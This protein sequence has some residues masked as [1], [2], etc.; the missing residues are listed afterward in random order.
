VGVRETLNKKKGVAMTAA[1]VVLCASVAL[2]AWESIG[3]GQKKITKAYYTVDDGKTWF[4]DDA[5]KIPP[6]DHNGQQACRVE[7]F[8]SADGKEFVGII[9]RYTD[10]VRDRLVELRAKPPAEQNQIEIGVVANAG[11][12]VKRPGDTNWV[13]R[14][15][16][17]GVAMMDVEAPDGGPVQGVI[18]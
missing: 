6:F 5:D 9:E 1:A 14:N 16:R 7:V 11:F 3:G 17:Q 15:S 13:A 4:A 12:E 2:I 18:P 10:A 8:K